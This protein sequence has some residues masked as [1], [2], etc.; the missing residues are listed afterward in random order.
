[1]GRLVHG[2]DVQLLIRGWS[3]SRLVGASRLL[4]RIGETGCGWRCRVASTCTSAVGR[5]LDRHEGVGACI[6]RAGG[7]DSEISSRSADAAQSLRGLREALGRGEGLVLVVV[8]VER[9]GA[10]GQGT[11]RAD[12]GSLGRLR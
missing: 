8:A 1:M 12:Y 2:V 5:R 7:C 4:L 3:P 9:H 11:L 10:N 6:R